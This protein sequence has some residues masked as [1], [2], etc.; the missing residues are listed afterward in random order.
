MKSVSITTL[1]AVSCA[2]FC[3]S[4]NVTGYCAP[5]EAELISVVIAGD[6]IK[7][8]ELLAAGANPNARREHETHDTPETTALSEALNLGHIEI[9][10]AILEKKPDDA[11]LI[12]AI[13]TGLGGY[14]QS[15]KPIQRVFVEQLL[16]QDRSEL[17]LSHSRY[18]RSE[19][20]ILA[21]LEKTPV[22]DPRNLQYSL[23]YHSWKTVRQIIDKAP[24]LKVFLAKPPQDPKLERSDLE[25]LPFYFV[26]RAGDHI[27]EEH[28]VAELL[29][30]M[31]KRGL[32]PSAWGEIS[33]TA[34]LQSHEYGLKFVSKALGYSGTEPPPLGYLNDDDR[35][36][37]AIFH[38]NETIAKTLRDKG[39][40]LRGH[41][42]VES[43]YAERITL[44]QKWIATKSYGKFNEHKVDP[45]DWFKPEQNPFRTA[46]DLEAIKW[47]IQCG[48]SPAKDDDLLTR[49]IC[50]DFEDKYEAIEILLKAGAPTVPLEGNTTS[51]LMGTLV[52]SKN[53]YDRVTLAKLLMK[54]GANPNLKDAGGKTAVQWAEQTFQIDLLAVLDPE[55][56]S[57][58]WE[59]YGMQPPNKW[60][61]MWSNELDEFK[62]LTFIFRPDGNVTMHGAVGEFTC[63][64]RAGADGTLLL[65]IIDESEFLVRKIAGTIELIPDADPPKSFTFEYK[66]TKHILKKVADPRELEQMLKAAQESV[67][68]E[69]D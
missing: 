33:K 27:H 46:P 40:V 42:I 49:I 66:G 68:D 64:W 47:L 37:S 2:I 60:V 19:N 62:T 8:R 6:L 56:K 54:H 1:L 44:A 9:M 65:D 53:N 26:N 32:A 18:I 69:E 38:N 59:L 7:T 39:A 21:L 4:L 16:A 20:A 43:H 12:Y 11:T 22:T 30:D 15:E 3:I 29:N 24:D 45:G 63:L 34:A 14:Q 51:K 48:V 28:L 57:K 25:L 55:R 61:G 23:S 35:L 52:I 36:A 10:T 13:T 41:S 17:L 50:H 5:S 67:K 31:S 58:I